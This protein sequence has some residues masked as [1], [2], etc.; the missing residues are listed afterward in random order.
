MLKTRKLKEKV[1]TPELKIQDLNGII[2]QLMQN[3]IDFYVIR[4]HPVEIDLEILDMIR[5]NGNKEEKWSRLDM[6]GMVVL[7]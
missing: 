5:L 1:W 3:G 7:L 2:T 6:N 4:I